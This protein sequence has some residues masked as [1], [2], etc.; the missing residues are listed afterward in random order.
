MGFCDKDQIWY[1]FDKDTQ[2]STCPDCGGKAS[3]K[4]GFQITTQRSF[5]ADAK[6]LSK[7]AQKK[8]GMGA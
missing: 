4:V 7:A 5:D 3:A 2:P 1:K 8:M 6:K